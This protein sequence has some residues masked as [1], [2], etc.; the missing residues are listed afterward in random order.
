MAKLAAAAALEAAGRKPMEVRLLSPALIITERKHNERIKRCITG[1]YSFYSCR[2]V[3]YP[4]SKFCGICFSTPEII[5][6]YPKTNYIYGDTPVFEIR[7]NVKNGEDF[8]I[9]MT[10]NYDE[11]RGMMKDFRIPVNNEE[12]KK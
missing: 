7:A 5:G 12:C 3:R 6:Y 8:I 1:G 9:A 4:G 10:S 2:Y 11:F